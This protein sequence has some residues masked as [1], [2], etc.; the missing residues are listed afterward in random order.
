MLYTLAGESPAPTDP[1]FYKTFIDRVVDRI[2]PTRVFFGSNWT[3]SEM[4]GSYANLI[5]ICDKYLE[6]KE[7]VSPEQFYTENSKKAYD[8]KIN[9]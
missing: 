6:K 4:H 7:D 2:G 1:D 9:K 5:R 8:L 3:L